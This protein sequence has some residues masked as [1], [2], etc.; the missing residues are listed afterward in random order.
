MTNQEILDSKAYK[1][2]YAIASGAEPPKAKTKYKTKTNESVTS[3]KS[4]TAF[5]SKGTRLKSKVKVTKPDMKKQPAKKTKAKGL[6]VLSEVALS[7]TE[8][9]KMATKRSKKDF[10]ISHASGSG[11]GVDTY[12]DKRT[13]SDGKGKP[14]LN[15]INV[16]Q[17]EYKEEDVDEG[18]HTPSDNE[19]T[20]EEKLDDKETIDDEEDDEVV[21]ELLKISSVSFD[22]PSKFLNLENPSLADNE[23]R[24]LMET[25]TPYATVIPELTSDVN[26]NLEQGDDEM[27]NVNQRGS[28]QHNVSQ[29]SGFKQ[30][31]EDTHV[32]L[33]PISNAQKA[34]EPIQSSSVSSDFTSKFLNLENPSPAD[35]EIASLMETSSPHATAIPKLTSGFTTTTPPLPPFF[36]PLLQQQTPTIP[37]PNYTN[38]TYLASK[39][40]E[41]VNVA[42]QLQKK[43]AQRRSSGRESRLPQSEEPSHTIEESGMQEDQEFVTRDNDEQPVD[44][45]VTKADWFKKPERP[46]TP[47]HDWSKRPFNLL[48]GTSKSIMEL[49]YHLEEC[50]KATAERLN[51]YNPEN[52]SYP[53]DVRNPL[54]LIQDRRGRKIIPKDYFI[55]KDL[56]YL[57]V[58]RLKIKKMYDYDHLEEIEVR[59]DDQQLYMFKEEYFK[60]LRLQDIEDMLLFLVQQ[61]LT[62]LTIDERFDL[63]VAL[64]YDH[65]SFGAFLSFEAKHRLEVHFLIE[66]RLGF[67]QEVDRKVL[68]EES[69]NESGSK[70]I[71]CF[72]SSFVEFIQPC[73]CFSGIVIAELR[74]GAIAW[75]AAYIGSS[76]I[77]IVILKN[78]KKVTEVI[79]VKN[80]RADNSRVSKWIVSLVEWN[81]S[82]S[83]TKSSIQYVQVWVTV[84]QIQN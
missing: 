74:F 23:I 30:E 55:N 15:L 58:T 66:R 25:S 38:P 72:N 81:S 26:V 1:E 59:R 5:A 80:W 17:T 79:D 61:K 20:D 21:K 6:A 37:T 42:V 9:I 83:S 24:S 33:T 56:E 76:S 52:K 8:Q 46:P 82:V 65:G 31:E 75:S 84:Q 73:F 63:N 27:T 54:P 36:N 39:I 67:L 68:R 7:K 19:F 69:A 44:K 50:S 41:A 22:F 70:L 45:E 53:F 49:E 18:V 40:K 64:H 32:T 57:K 77:W 43:Q 14:D 11:D 62:N 16:D 3:P 12:D 60:R 47:D 13:E 4:K 10:H 48:K 29:E 34:D 35:N 51:W 28:E 2:Y 71:P 78:I